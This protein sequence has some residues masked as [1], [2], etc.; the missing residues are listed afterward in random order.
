MVI[1]REAANIE[2][3]HCGTEQ[4]ISGLEHGNR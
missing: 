4:R 1:E 3:R 2:C